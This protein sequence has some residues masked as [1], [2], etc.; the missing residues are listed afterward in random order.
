MK[1]TG[2][3][4]REPAKMR[5]HPNRGVKNAKGQPRH[6]RALAV[7]VERGAE[8]ARV[9]PILLLHKCGLFR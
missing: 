1:K 3:Y 6:E 5:W 9:R 8:M 4:K 7:R 2:P